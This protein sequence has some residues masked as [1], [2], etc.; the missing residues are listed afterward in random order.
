V[1]QNRTARRRESS[2]SFGCSCRSGY[3]AGTGAPPHRRH[4]R[5]AG[6]PE[7]TATHI[8]FTCPTAAAPHPGSVRVLDLGCAT[9]QFSTGEAQYGLPLF[10]LLA[11]LEAPEW[12]SVQSSCALPA[13]PAASRQRRHAAMGC[14][15]AERRLLCSILTPV[16][17]CR[18]NRVRLPPS[19]PKT[20]SKHNVIRWGSLVA[21]WEMKSGGGSLP[22]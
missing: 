10:L 5:C 18:C 13:S 14:S 4:A 15:A 16:A 3:S 1:W 12:G 8:I 22:Y 9:P 17:P 19:P 2:S 11:Y 20:L 6:T 21:E 7:E